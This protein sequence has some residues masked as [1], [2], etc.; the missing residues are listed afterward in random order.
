MNKFKT[1]IPVRHFGPDLVNLFLRELEVSRGT[2]NAF[3]PVH[4]SPNLTKIPR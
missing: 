1:D 2:D 4:V 3:Y